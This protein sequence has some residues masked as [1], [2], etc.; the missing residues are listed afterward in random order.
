M[1]CIATLSASEAA[2]IGAAVGGSAAILGAGVTA[3]FNRQ[4]MREE[5]EERR[6]QQERNRQSA[7]N[8]QLR[9][10]ML[11]AALAFST[12]LE[13][14]RSRTSPIAVADVETIL[15]TLDQRLAD[16]LSQLGSISLLFGADSTVSV[17]A[18][19]AHYWAINTIAK[20]RQLAEIDINDREDS[21]IGPEIGK[22]AKTLAESL[23][24]FTKAAAGAIERGPTWT[25]TK[26]SSP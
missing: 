4:V 24:K 14:V 6:K 26:L 7:R 2:V 16:G 9:R 18:R 15:P 19:A 1:I 20:V 22:H 21:P 17:E 11:E 10:Q 23:S 13:W 3:F 25:Q 5:R 8:D 12:A